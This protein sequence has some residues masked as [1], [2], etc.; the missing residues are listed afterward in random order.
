MWAT[1]LAGAKVLRI[2]ERTTAEAYAMVKTIIGHDN[3]YGAHYWAQ[4][5]LGIPEVLLSGHHAEVSKWR[6]AEREKTTRERRPDLWNARTANQQA[7][8]DFKPSKDE[9]R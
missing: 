6:A 8:G 7:K 1:R 9:D 4:Y 3:E 2:G 5:L